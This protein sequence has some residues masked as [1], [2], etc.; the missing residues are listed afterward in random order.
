MSLNRSILI[1]LIILLLF[2]TYLIITRPELPKAK[3]N[4]SGVTELIKTDTKL[5]EGN[6][7]AFGKDVTVHYTGWLYESN[8]PDHH[9]KKFDSSR[10]R[11]EPLSFR[12]GAGK[13]IMGWD[14]GLLG[15]KVGG[16]RT[17]IIPPDLGYGARRANQL[18][19]PNST[20]IFDIELLNVN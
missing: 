2:I 12:L 8:S 11:G 7:A 4:T 6:S 15:M 17:L 1:P 9:G 18:I 16:Q 5:G 14:H 19:P 3:I 13:V 20:L 10:E